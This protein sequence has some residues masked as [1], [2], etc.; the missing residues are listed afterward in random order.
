MND[1]EITKKCAEAMGVDAWTDINGRWYC[2]VRGQEAIFAPLHDDAQAMALL[3]KFRAQLAMGG[4]LR[5]ELCQ[6]A[7]FEHIDM[8][9]AICECVAKMDSKSSITESNK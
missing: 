7:E 5:Y 2:Y 4:M 3:K 9:R 8:N 6:C 1:L